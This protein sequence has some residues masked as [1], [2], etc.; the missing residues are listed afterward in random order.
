LLAS[1][2]FFRCIVFVSANPWL[3]F[4]PFRG[5]NSEIYRRKYFFGI[6]VCIYRFSGSGITLNMIKH[7]RK[8]FTY[9]HRLLI[10][11]FI[12][13]GHEWDTYVRMNHILNT[14]TIDLP[15]LV[16]FVG[17]FKQSNTH[18]FTWFGNLPM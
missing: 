4:L 10:S 2:C 12:V 14:K 9:P 16:I 11:R 1:C 8:I 5:F 7:G 3:L 13:K 6:S 18:K 15:S 17:T